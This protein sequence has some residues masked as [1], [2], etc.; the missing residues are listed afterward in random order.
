MQLYPEAFKDLFPV[1]PVLISSSPE[2]SSV[3]TCGEKGS[4]Y[5]TVTMVYGLS[6]ILVRGNLLAVS[7]ASNKE[8]I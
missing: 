2:C 4:A 7:A 8:M 5:V 6:S 1:E 3:N